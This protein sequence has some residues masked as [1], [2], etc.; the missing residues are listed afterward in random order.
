MKRKCKSVNNND[1]NI[2]CL[3]I[4]QP[5]FY[6]QKKKKSLLKLLKLKHALSTEPL[7][8]LSPLS[9]DVQECCCL[10]DLLLKDRFGGS[11]KPCVLVQLAGR[12]PLLPWTQ[13]ARLGAERGP[14]GPPGTSL[15][16]PLRMNWACG[17][18]LMAGSFFCLYPD[19]SILCKHFPRTP[20]TWKLSATVLLWS[21]YLNPNKQ[22]PGM[23]M[24]SSL[25]K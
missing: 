17:R 25:L 22:D 11:E 14:S 13:A 21:P 9:Y 23:L 18:L 8:H 24:N 20:H 1:D 2:F 3:G 15:S 12:H 19:N 5:R 10:G 7:C 16:T 4:I 6:H